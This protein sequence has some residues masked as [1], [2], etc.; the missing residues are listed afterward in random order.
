VHN[1]DGY[2]LLGDKIKS[3]NLGNPMVVGADMSVDFAAGKVADSLG[4]HSECLMKKRDLSD[5]SIATNGSVNVS[6]KNVVIVDDI[7]S[8]GGTMA[9]AAKSARA[10]GAASITIAAVHLTKKSAIT[11]LRPLSDSFFTTDT[12]ENPLAQVSVVPKIAETIKKML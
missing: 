3:M 2:N 9:N 7:I 12:I 8:S 6:G 10:S 4:C 5:G 1:I 11:K